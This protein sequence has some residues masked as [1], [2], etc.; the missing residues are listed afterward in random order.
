MPGPAQVRSTE[1]IAAFRN[2]LGTFAERV[3]AGLDALEGELRRAA[4]WIDNDRPGYWREQ[5]RQAEDGLH[6][7][8]MELERCLMMTLAGERPACREQKAAVRDW[9]TRIEYCRDKIERVRKWQRT[10]HHELLEHRGR[11][12]QLRALIEQEVPQARETLARVVARIDAYQIERPPE[13]WQEATAGST[14]STPA[15]APAASVAPPASA[16]TRPVAEA[17]GEPALPDSA[18][19]ADAA[20]LSS[21]SEVS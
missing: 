15:P 18:N 5:L 10:F 19:P 20:K 12:G 11:L 21:V 6:E 4:D 17:T 16:A 1:A 7:A 3:V 9:Q 14:A 2:S 13:A 8:R